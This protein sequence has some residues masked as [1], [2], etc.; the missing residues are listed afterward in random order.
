M[1][2]S[3]IFFFEEDTEAGTQAGCAG[4]A[5]ES[6]RKGSIIT[7]SGRQVGSRTI[8]RGACRWFQTIWLQSPVYLAQ[9]FRWMFPS[10]LDFL[11]LENNITFEDAPLDQIREGLG[12]IGRLGHKKILF[13]LICITSYLSLKKM[14]DMRYTSVKSRVQYDFAFLGVF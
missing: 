9:H 4:S 14:V 13:A 11:I 3:A 10:Q 6:Q 5:A 7:Y 2:F 8:E 1:K 12:R